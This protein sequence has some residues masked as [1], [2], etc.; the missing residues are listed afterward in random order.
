[1][2]DCFRNSDR[3]R[4]FAIFNLISSSQSSPSSCPTP[5]RSVPTNS[6]TIR[7]RYIYQSSKVQQLFFLTCTDVED[8]IK[9]HIHNLY[10]SKARSLVYLLSTCNEFYTYTIPQREHEKYVYGVFKNDTFCLPCGEAAQIRFK[11]HYI[12]A[13]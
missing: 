6:S 3:R 9:I 1:M 10:Q 7:E 11:D 2:L 8:F 12:N 4:W 13:T 5:P